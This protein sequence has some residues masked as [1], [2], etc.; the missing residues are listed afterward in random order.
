M[1]ARCIRCGRVDG[2]QDAPYIAGKGSFVPDDAL[3]AYCAPC[4]LALEN[5]GFR[6]ALEK[7]EAE[8]RLIEYPADEAD[9]AD[10]LR[11]LIPGLLLD[12]YKA[13]EETGIDMAF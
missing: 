4:S 9:W 2:V 10:S 6:A 8:A 5:A 13:G 1:S 12:A 3:F 7:W 11:I